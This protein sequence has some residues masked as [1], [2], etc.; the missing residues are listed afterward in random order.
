MAVQSHGGDADA[1][2]VQSESVSSNAQYVQIRN[3]ILHNDQ[4]NVF[5]QFVQDNSVQIADNQ[6]A[7]IHE[8]EERH[9]AILGQSLDH[10]HSH[11]E[12]IMRLGA[13]RYN[14]L[15]RRYL[16]LES[17]SQSRFQEN[18]SLRDQNN[19]LMAR[20]QEAEGQVVATRIHFESEREAIVAQGKESIRLACDEAKGR[21]DQLCQDH[22]N[23]MRSCDISHQDEINMLARQN[24]DLQSRIVFLE[25]QTSRQD[26]ECQRGRSPRHDVAGANLMPSVDIS[27]PAGSVINPFTE[28]A[29]QMQSELSEYLGPRRAQPE[30]AGHGTSKD[31]RKDDHEVASVASPSV[32]SAVN[33][34]DAVLEML[35]KVLEKRDDNEGRPNAKEAE[36]IKLNNLSALEKPCP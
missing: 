5:F 29:R 22:E 24:E 11:F 16:Q 28:S 31:D 6:Q 3:Q 14:D 15:E 34:N 21:I 35:R 12:S 33:Q 4:M 27:T 18:A 19:A 20:V 23:M 10:M 7:V 17:A 8:A 26:C 36:S 32:R 9:R 25:R 2:Q 1:L 13:D 30:A